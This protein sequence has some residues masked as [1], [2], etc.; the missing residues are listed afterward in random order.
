L[1]FKDSSGLQVFF[2]FLSGLEE[3][4]KDALGHILAVGPSCLAD[5][6]QRYY[7]FAFLHRILLAG[8]MDG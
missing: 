5:N 1:I 3:F 6:I 4:M 2:D 8:C 7:D